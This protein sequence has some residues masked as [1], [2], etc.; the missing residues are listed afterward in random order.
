[1]KIVTSTELIIVGISNVAMM[2]SGRVSLEHH[3]PYS[4]LSLIYIKR[5]LDDQE[6]QL[7]LKAILMCDDKH[8]WQNYL[9]KAH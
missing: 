1:M 8:G 4:S 6:C 5:V 2:I 7:H 3:G 9:H